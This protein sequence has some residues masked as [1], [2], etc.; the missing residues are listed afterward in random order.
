MSLAGLLKGTTLVLETGSGKRLEGKISRLPTSSG[1][2]L[3][4]SQSGLTGGGGSGGGGLAS[5]SGVGGS[6]ISNSGGGAPEEA[7]LYQWV[8]MSED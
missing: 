1:R 2:P 7:P 6:A 4:S 3:L 8:Q 5:G